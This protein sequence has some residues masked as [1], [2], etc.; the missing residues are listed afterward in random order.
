M[1]DSISIGAA[2]RD[3]HIKDGRLTGT[4]DGD[5]TISGAVTHSGSVTNSGAVTQ[6]G[7]VTNSGNITNSG[8]VTQSGNLTISSGKFLSLGSTTGFVVAA[9]TTNATPGNGTINALAGVF[10]T[11]NLTTA[12]NTIETFLLTNS[13][14]K[15]NDTVLAFP[16]GG[17]LTVG[18][19]VVTSTVV[20]AT[21]GNVTISLANA[22]T[23][24][25]INGAVKI[26]FIVLK[27]VAA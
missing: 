20:G 6:S 21:G 23:A 3:Q 12:N 15:T 4:I 26:G 16:V 10:Q 17:N 25:A 18:V 2:F 13:Q 8:P 7:N 14:I 5:H 24:G 27:S 22:G 1:P 11:A 9:N 19:P